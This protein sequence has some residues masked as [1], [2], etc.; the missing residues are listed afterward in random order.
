MWCPKLG[1][2]VLTLDSEVFL[3]KNSTPESQKHQFQWFRSLV[4]TLSHVL[5]ISKTGRQKFV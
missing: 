3:Y 1:K 2:F 4:L 5:G